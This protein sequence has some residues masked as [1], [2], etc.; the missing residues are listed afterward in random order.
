MKNILENVQYLVELKI[1]QLKEM[2]KEKQELIDT[3]N[4]MIEMYR[5][6]VYGYQEEIEKA[7][8]QLKT[9]I[10]SMIPNDEYKET[11]TQF[12]YKA[13][14]GQVVIK[15]ETEKI[16]LN[17]EFDEK[18][19]PEDYIKIKKSVD[20]I[21]FKKKLIVQNEKVVNKETGEIIESCNVEKIPEE[22]KLKIT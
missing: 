21:N 22:I 11:K 15:K 2:Q 20:W 1:N 5:G 16:V 4:K 7:E 9:A 14:S 6:K 18:E 12:S 19:I 17:K 3:C 8:N 10:I 13:P